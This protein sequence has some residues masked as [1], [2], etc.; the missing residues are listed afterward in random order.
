VA[1]QVAGSL[2]RGVLGLGAAGACALLAAAGAAEAQEASMVKALSRDYN[3]SGLDLYREMA[4]GPGN[5]VLSPFSIGSAMAMVRA[6]ARGETEREMASALKHSLPSASVD[7]A[8]AALLAHLK[9]YDRTADPAFCPEGTRWAGKHCEAPVAGSHCPPLSTRQGGLCIAPPNLRSAT[10]MVANALALPKGAGGV[11]PAYATILAD[12]Y[13][14]AVLPGAGVDDINAWVTA[15]TAG[16]IERIIGALP[17]ES[18]PVLLNAVYLKAAWHSPFSKSATL[19]GDFN[20]STA[21]RVRVPMMHQEE[22]FVLVERAGYRALRLDYIQRSLA[23]IVVLPQKLEGLGDVTRRLD[24]A[25][26]AALITAMDGAPAR[27]VALTL[28]RF[29]AAFSADLVPPFQRAGMRLAF[30]DAADFSGMTGDGPRVAALKIGAIRHRAVI[31]VD[32]W[33]SEAAAAT[34]V[35]MMVT[36]APLETLQPVAFVVDRPFIFLV[37]DRGS[38]AVLFQGRIRDP[39]RT[40]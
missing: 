26:L 38:G 17:E 31:D 4:L 7:A 34:S 2:R 39:R 8:N 37:V 21:E 36:S 11:S 24:A 28:P 10:L 25:E 16:K 40:D 14:A 12:S 33:G 27:H 30:S 15:R 35:G 5:V 22:A 1:W 6:G 18:G 20:L 29:K 23:M 13:A 19:E 32:E 9:G 3:A